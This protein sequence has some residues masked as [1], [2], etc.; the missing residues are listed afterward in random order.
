VAKTALARL[1]KCA[2]AAALATETELAWEPD[3]IYK[4]KLPNAA[5]T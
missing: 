1:D 4:A 2:R 3:H 5:L